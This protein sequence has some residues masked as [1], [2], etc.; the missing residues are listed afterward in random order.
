MIFVILYLL[1]FPLMVYENFF[2][3]RLRAEKSRLARSPHFY[4]AAP[5][6]VEKYSLCDFVRL[7]E[8]FI[9]CQSRLKGLRFEQPFRSSMNVPA[10]EKPHRA[11]VNCPG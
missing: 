5:R 2:A 1:S 7:P 3:V 11:N 10:K 6:S 8:P 9:S 4:L